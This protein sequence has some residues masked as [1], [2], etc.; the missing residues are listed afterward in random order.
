MQDLSTV[1]GGIWL[2]SWRGAAEGVKLIA[3][4]LHCQDNGPT[5]NVDLEAA[6]AFH[7]RH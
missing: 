6:R 3:S 7:L 2:C 5:L 1:S 4:M